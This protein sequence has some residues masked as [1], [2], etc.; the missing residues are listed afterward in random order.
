M[1]DGTIVSLCLGQS[2]DGSQSSPTICVL[3]IIGLKCKIKMLRGPLRRRTGNG[4]SEAS[5]VVVATNTE[6]FL[7]KAGPLQKGIKAW[8]ISCHLFPCG[9]SPS[10]DSLKGGGLSFSTSLA[11]FIIVLWILCKENFFFYM[12]S[13]CKG[14]SKGAHIKKT[15]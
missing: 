1:V 14:Q 3:K 5:L 7:W 2:S 4:L 15:Q 12:C 9:D 10:L 13:L 6:Q 11:G 8:R